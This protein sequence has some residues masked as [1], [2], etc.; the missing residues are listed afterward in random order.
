MS[1]VGYVINHLVVTYIIAL[2]LKHIE[3][4]GDAVLNGCYQLPHAVFIGW[5]FFGPSRGG[6]GPVKLG[7]EATT[8][9]CW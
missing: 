9:S 4:Q 2:S 7:Y 6:E 1:S 3:H 5:V 8:G